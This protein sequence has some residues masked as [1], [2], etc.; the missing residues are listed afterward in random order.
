MERN[1]QVSLFS[2]VSSNLKLVFFPETSTLC[3]SLL[4][5]CFALLHVENAQ[6]D[7]SILKCCGSVGSDIYMFPEYIKLTKELQN[8]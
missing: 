7:G 1:I 2:V 6:R 3:F 8:P 5:T 4:E